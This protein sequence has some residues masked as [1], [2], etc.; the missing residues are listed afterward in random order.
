MDNPPANTGPD[1]ADVLPIR[2][3]GYR[4]WMLRHAWTRRMEAAVAPTSLTHMQFFLLRAVDHAT[5]FG[6]TPSQT[7][8]ADGLQIDRMTVSKVVRTLEAKGLLDRAVHPDD[9]RA[10]G[11]ALTPEGR[12]LIRRA[13][14]LVHAEQER[15]FNRLGPAGKAAFSQSLDT[16][17]ELEGVDLSIPISRKAAGKPPMPPQA[18][19]RTP[20]KETV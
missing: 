9:A 6:D 2:S 3:F 1:P 15:F 13:T 4:L 11:L 19:L 17:L 10:K 7:R 16:L 14:N 5:A 12:A 20:L 18:P 8:I